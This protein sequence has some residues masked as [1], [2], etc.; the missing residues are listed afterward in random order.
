[1][2]TDFTE[3]YQIICFLLTMV[4]WFLLHRV[5]TC[6]R[7]SDKQI[8]PGYV[9]FLPNHTDYYVIDFTGSKLY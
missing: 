2:L 6:S 8:L 1:M 7:L 4:R 3:F 5:L 9:G